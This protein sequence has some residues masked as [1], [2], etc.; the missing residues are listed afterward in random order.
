[1]FHFFNHAVFKSLLFVNAAAVEE[2]AGTTEMARLG[3][4]GAKMPWTSTTSAIGS[5][6]VAGVPPFAGF[7]SKLLIILALWQAHYY[8]YAGVAVVVSVLTLAYML[9][10]QRKVFFGQS[11]EEVGAVREARAGLVVPAVLL[12]LITA[13]V[14][15]GFIFVP[16]VWEA[17][18]SVL[19]P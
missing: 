16:C 7:W 13:G 3:G 5:L 10:M 15:V 18:K 12:A 6:S 14:G 9:V 4:L 11:V 1:M 17:L 19:N 8:A 2:Q